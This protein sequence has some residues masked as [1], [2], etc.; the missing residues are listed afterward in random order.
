M[1]DMLIIVE[2]QSAKILDRKKA[3]ILAC[4]CIIF[5]SPSMPSHR[6]IQCDEF[7]ELDSNLYRLFNEFKEQGLRET[8]DKMI[9]VREKIIAHISANEIEES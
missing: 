9:D 6:N 7:M 8:L 1:S 5:T 2:Y 3:K 4:G